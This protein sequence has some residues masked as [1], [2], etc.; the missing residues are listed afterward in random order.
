[1]HKSIKIP[2]FT[3]MNKGE[4]EL[5]DYQIRKGRYSLFYERKKTQEFPKE[6]SKTENKFSFWN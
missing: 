4:Y 5:T 1:M 2:F 6:L 3:G